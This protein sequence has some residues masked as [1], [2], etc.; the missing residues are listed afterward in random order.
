MFSKR[1][2]LFAVVLCCLFAMTPSA[3]FSQGRFVRHG[4]RDGYGPVRR[5]GCGRDGYPGRSFDERHAKLLLPMMQG[6]LFSPT[7]VPGTYK[8][9]HKIKPDFRVDED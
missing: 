9:D 5:S 1:V 3:L 2:V 8:R 4:C 6:D 7:V